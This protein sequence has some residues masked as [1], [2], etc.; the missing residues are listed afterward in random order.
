[1]ID[2]AIKMLR[3]EEADL[4]GQVSKLRAAI[5]ALA[6]KSGAVARAHG[7][8]RTSAGKAI[9][10]RVNPLA[11]KSGVVRS[12]SV[13][14]TAASGISAVRVNP[15]QGKHLSAAHKKA[16]RDGLAKRKKLHLRAAA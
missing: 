8:A 5:N 2:D 14:R 16:I 9:S 3:K 15:M 4:L 7:V 12:A 6:G 13:S 10:A 1:M 11:G